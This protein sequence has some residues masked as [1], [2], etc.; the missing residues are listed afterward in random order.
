MLPP[1]NKAPCFALYD[2]Q[3]ELIHTQTLI[4]CKLILYFYPTHTSPLCVGLL[5]KLSEST[6]KLEGENFKIL[7]IS[8]DN[9][10]QNRVL[11]NKHNLCFPI[12]S[13]QKGHVAE[14]YNINTEKQCFNIKYHF[15][16]R[17]LFTIDAEG[18]IQN[19]FR[20]ID[21]S[22]NLSIITTSST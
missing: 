1:K 8:R 3:G 9:I 18:C 6:E 11:K 20:K 10:Q 13:D 17:S 14:L 5:K 4:N 2:T 22:F 19:C 7:S 16:D 12:L 15:T 21:N